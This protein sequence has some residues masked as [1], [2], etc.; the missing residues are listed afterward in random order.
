[1]YRGNLHFHLITASF[2][3][4]GFSVPVDIGLRNQINKK[5]ES[6]LSQ[7][8]RVNLLNI[9]LHPVLSVLVAEIMHHF[10]PKMV[11]MHNYCPANSTGTKQCNW[12]LLNRYSTKSLVFKASYYWFFH[13]CVTEIQNSSC[14]FVIGN[15]DEMFVPCLQEFFLYRRNLLGFF[16]Q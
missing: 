5:I 6:W 16:L 14:L 7:L 3:S 10:F 11:E 8:K 13:L 1:M 2:T 9:S 15:T 12:D 4:L